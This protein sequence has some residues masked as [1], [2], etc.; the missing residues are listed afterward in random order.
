MRLQ[1]YV[2]LQQSRDLK[3]A[4]IYSSNSLADFT[5]LNSSNSRS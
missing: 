5:T 1:M 2:V 4:V 3:F